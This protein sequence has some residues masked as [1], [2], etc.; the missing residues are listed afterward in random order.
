MRVLRA[1]VVLAGIY[2][3]GVVA[4]LDLLALLGAWELFVDDVWSMTAP[5]AV[6]F[7]FAF[8][9]LVITRRIGFVLLWLV[10]AALWAWMLLAPGF[11]DPFMLLTYGVGHPFRFLG[12]SVLA[13]PLFTMSLIADAQP[14]LVKVG[15][16]P[17][18]T[19]SVMVFVWILLAAAG[20]IMRNYGHPHYPW[21]S[22]SAAIT[23]AILGWVWWA[24][25]PFFIA[26]FAVRAFWN[27]SKTAE[28]VDAAA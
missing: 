11:S 26:R 7:G 5:F 6:L 2:T 12:W 24:P 13:L 14:S 18:R 8:L 1:G 20:L 4:L 19:V 15:R 28:L 10:L 16:W 21:W 9:V 27:G 22:E 25:V 3:I 17:V 23:V